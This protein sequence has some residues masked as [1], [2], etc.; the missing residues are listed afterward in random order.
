MQ[1]PG[2][3]VFT[4]DGVP[5]SHRFAF[6]KDIL[7]SSLGSRTVKRR[8]S[9]T[10]HGRFELSQIDCLSIVNGRCAPLVVSRTPRDISRMP[11]ESLHW[12]SPR[13]GRVAIF[14][15]G[16]VTELR[17]GELG[18]VLTGEP[19]ALDYLEQVNA[20]TVDVPIPKIGMDLTRLRALSAR[21]LAQKSSGSRAFS[22]M[23]QTLPLSRLR[24]E[25]AAD[26]RLSDL[27]TDM[28]GVIVEEFGRD[29]PLGS[30][31]APGRAERVLQYID[32]TLQDALL[33]PRRAAA[34]LG[35]SERAVHNAM[36]ETGE[37]F[38]QY[39]R[40]RRLDRI[41]SGLDVRSPQD[42]GLAQLIFEWGFNDMS[43]F[44]RAFRRRFDCTP[45]EWIA[46]SAA[47]AR[48]PAGQPAL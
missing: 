21:N 19:F 24:G 7:G 36:A 16:R 11:S 43:T 3:R 45:T 26:R 38:M 35:L 10:F 6:W 34:A 22:V 27:A 1:Q 31:L 41:V 5:V 12:I 37:T 20:M 29:A 4:T 18:F 14:Q 2:D 25:A 30:D 46:R 9:M 33:S 28:M 48:D 23:L 8:E 44:Y 17:S 13:Q 15:D 40:N 42:P 39:V 47:E 32:T